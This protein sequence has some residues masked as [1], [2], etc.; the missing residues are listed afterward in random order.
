MET[1]R[2]RLASLHET[3]EQL[4]RDADYHNSVAKN[5][6]EQTEDFDRCWAEIND[7]VKRRKS[8]VS[9]IVC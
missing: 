8:M 5:I 6:R 9:V 2:N 7:T 3:G 1:Q 4:I